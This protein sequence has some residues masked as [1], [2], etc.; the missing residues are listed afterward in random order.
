MDF[1]MGL[2][3]VDLTRWDPSRLRGAVVALMEGAPAALAGHLPSVAHLKT[4]AAATLS[5][6]DTGSATYFQSM[7]ELAYLVASADGFADEERHALAELLSKL[8][9][10]AVAT[11]V[12]ELHLRDLDDACELLGRRERLRR[13][14]E[15]FGDG[16]SRSEALGFAALVAI[17]DGKLAEPE[18]GALSELGRFFDMSADEVAAVVDDVVGRLGVELERG[19]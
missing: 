2:S 5:E 13:A 7:L 3:T 4:G 9:G 14:A 1:A 17:A 18:A 12:L 8:T 19:R 15:D 16:P 10:S 6:G 11:D